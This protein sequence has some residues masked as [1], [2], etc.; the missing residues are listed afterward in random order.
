MRC[1]RYNYVVMTVLLSSVGYLLILLMMVWDYDLT[2]GQGIFLF[3]ITSNITAMRSTSLCR[4]V[5]S[6]CRILTH[7]GITCLRVQCIC[8]CSD[9][10]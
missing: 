4:A 6:Y 10:V 2:F 8:V 9:G 1:V 7:S 3:V 5:C